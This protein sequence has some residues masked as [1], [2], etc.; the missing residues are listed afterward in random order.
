MTFDRYAS[1]SE[2]WQD[3]LSQDSRHQP[4]SSTAST[5]STA[6][7]C[8]YSK[9][10]AGAKS[11]TWCSLYH[12]GYSSE[13]DSIM[14]MYTPGDA[15]P[16]EVRYNHSQWSRTQAPLKNTIGTTPHRE[17]D[18]KPV[19]KTV[20]F[21][22]GDA[23]G[24]DPYETPVRSLERLSSSRK[25]DV[26][27]VMPFS[28]SAY[29]P[30]TSFAPYHSVMEDLPSPVSSSKKVSPSYNA[31]TPE[32]LQQHDD[33]GEEEEG[34]DDYDYRQPRSAMSAK[35]AGHEEY[36]EEKKPRQPRPQEVES[37]DTEYYADDDS[38]RRS[39]VSGAIQTQ[40][41]ELALYIFSGIMLIFVMEQ[42]VQIGLHM[43]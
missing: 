10:S 3:D 41:L 15:I 30:S 39:S 22:P 31:K 5:A 35:T 18:P 7:T 12:D 2:A 23:D 24:E 40:Y 11:N 17:P 32:L 20:R 38:A 25:E 9:G 26:N 28:A 6:P 42:F 13:V 29:E 37:T 16:S 43:R 21:Y 36:E 34:D 8:K 27:M 33:G 19:K 4:A 1:L 14:D